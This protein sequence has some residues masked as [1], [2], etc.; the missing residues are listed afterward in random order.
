VCCA[1]LDS[2]R[3]ARSK[4]IGRRRF[5]DGS[6]GRERELAYVG[7]N[8]KRPSRQQWAREFTPPQQTAPTPTQMSH[9]AEPKLNVFLSPPTSALASLSSAPTMIDDRGAEFLSWPH[10]FAFQLIMRDWRRWSRISGPLRAESGLHWW[11][12]AP[13]GGQ[14]SVAARS[15]DGG[16]DLAVAPAESG[17][18]RSNL[19]G[20]P[21]S[22]S[23]A[24]LT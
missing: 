1:T 7:M 22:P 23:R 21:L 4:G 6:G 12:W 20:R 13:L 15:G 3:A 24:R 8:F 18:R 17:A 11:A 19:A 16:A 9:P 2:R 10:R 5:G 14:Q